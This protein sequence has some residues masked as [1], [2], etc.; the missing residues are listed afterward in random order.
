MVNV[1]LDT[2]FLMIPFQFN[3]HIF[4]ELRRILDVPFEVFILEESVNELNYIIQNQRG[5]NKEFARLALQYI[6]MKKIPFFDVSKQKDLYIT[7]NSKRDIVDD[8][9]VAIASEE[10][11]IAT[12]DIEL[13]KRIREKSNIKIIYLRAKNRLEIN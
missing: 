6:K 8:M 3:V 7:N 2:N 1:I 9:L 4:E 12:Q 13:K 5:K 10:N 11:L